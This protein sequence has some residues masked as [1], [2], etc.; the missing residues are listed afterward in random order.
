MTVYR[1]GPRGATVYSP[2]GAPLG[3]LGAGTRVVEDVLDEAE[4]VGRQLGRKVG[5]YKRI[6]VY[7]D[8][9]IASGRDLADKGASG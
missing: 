2:D 1:V 9:R 3:R 4:E 8:K 7:D 5:A 6:P